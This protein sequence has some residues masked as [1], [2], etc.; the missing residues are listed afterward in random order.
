MKIDVLHVPDCPNLAPLLDHLRMVT[1]LRVTT[2][3]VGSA[4]EAE[5]FGMAGSPTLLING[6]DPFA[7]PGQ[8]A[9]VSCRL[10]R[11]EDGRIVPAPSVEQ[12]RDAIA[13][14]QDAAG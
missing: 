8:C 9:V 6:V 2:R 5:E 10:Y 14:G 13:A 3:E 11:D 1:D 7:A 12:L 4:A